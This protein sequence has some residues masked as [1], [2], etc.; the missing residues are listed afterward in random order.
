[1]HIRSL[2]NYGVGIHNGYEDH[3]QFRRSLS[4]FC[5]P[6]ECPQALTCDKGKVEGS[7]RNV[8]APQSYFPYPSL[9][10]WSQF[11]TVPHVGANT[12]RSTEIVH[13]AHAMKRFWRYKFCHR[14]GYEQKSE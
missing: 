3:I 5:P 2:Y 12:E 8:D 14:S 9:C 11:E 13:F 4:Q 6:V 7:K 10:S 1:M